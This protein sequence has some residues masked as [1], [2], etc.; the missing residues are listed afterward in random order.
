MCTKFAV[1][2]ASALLLAIA[3]GES[4]SSKVRYLSLQ[5]QRRQPLLPT[6]VVFDHTTLYP[7]VSCFRI[8]SIVSTPTALLAFAEARMDKC[9]DCV[10]NG[11]ALRRS[12]DSGRTWLPI[13]Y[14]VPADPTDPADPTSSIGGN[15]AAVYDNRTKTVILQFCRGMTPTATG[16]QTCS[17]AKSN[18]QVVS[19]R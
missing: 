14:P 17:P 13:Q 2:G 7:N 15:P 8:P 5:Q 6:S 3:A 11:I 9:D 4:P 19:R 1:C 16:G 10:R 18:W 12:T